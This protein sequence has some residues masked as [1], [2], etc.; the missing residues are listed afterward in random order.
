MDPGSHCTSF[1]NTEQDVPCP[2]TILPCANG[3]KCSQ[4]LLITR[5]HLKYIAQG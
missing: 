3:A 5:V 1:T 2:G 4:G